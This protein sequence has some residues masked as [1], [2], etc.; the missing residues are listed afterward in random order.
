MSNLIRKAQLADLPR[1][2]DIYNDAVLHSTATFDLSPP[3]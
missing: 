1:L 2:K 3:R